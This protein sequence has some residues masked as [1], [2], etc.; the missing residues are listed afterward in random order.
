MAALEE[1]RDGR[2]PVTVL[3]GFL[4]AGKTTLLKHVLENREEV[5]VAVIVNDVGAINLD[6]ALIKDSKLVREDEKLVELTNGCICCTRKDELLEEVVE[7]AS[8]KDEADASKRRFDALLVESTGASD[9]AS[10]AA[11]FAQDARVHEVA[12]LDLLCT[13]V[14]AFAFEDNFKSVT[15]RDDHEGHAHGPG[16]ACG[17][18]EPAPLVE[19]LAS[20]VEFADVVLLGVGNGFSP[21]S[22]AS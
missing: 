9:P 20:Q 5:R 14:D 21:F 19:L 2:L 10:V 18:G 17:T 8:L 22:R 13:V 12:K 6:E 15:F 11:A 4:G 16:E 3:S 7:L 1:E